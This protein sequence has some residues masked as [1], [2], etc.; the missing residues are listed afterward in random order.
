[1]KTISITEAGTS[2]TFNVNRIIFANGTGT[3]EEVF[4]PQDQISYDINTEYGKIIT[5]E[6]GSAY[7]GASA[8]WTLDA[9]KAFTGFD[10]NFTTPDH[11]GEAWRRIEAYSSGTRVRFFPVGTSSPTD[12]YVNGVWEDES[13]KRI[14]ISGG[15]DAFKKT[16]VEWLVGSARPRVSTNKALHTFEMAILADKIKALSGETDNQTIIELIGLLDD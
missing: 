16:F 10:I 5:R 13:Y 14:I 15:A 9:L 6:F 3:D 7:T 11:S 4:V 2:K 8:Q 1:M 12:V